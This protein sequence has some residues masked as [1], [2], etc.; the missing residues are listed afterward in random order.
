MKELIKKAKNLYHWL[1]VF[2]GS[3]ATGFPGRKM[4]VIGITGT[5]GKTSAVE[6]L[7][8]ILMASGK[9]TAVLSSLRVK[10]GDKVQKNLTGNTMPGRAYLQRFLRRAEG[11][12]V[13]YALVEVTSEGAVQHRHKFVNWNI[14]AL[15]NLHPEHIESHGSLENYRRAKLSFLE[16]AAKKGAKI[17]LNQNDSGSE[18]FWEKLPTSSIIFFSSSLLPDLPP[19]VFKILKGDFNRDNIALAVAIAEHLH[20]DKETIRQ[21]LLNF[22]GIPG[23][24]EYIIKEPFAVIVDYAH[25]PDSLEAV[26]Q[27]VKPKDGRLICVLGAA[28]G[29][30]DKWKRPVFGK[31]A[32]DYCEEIILTNEDPFDENPE[33]ILQEIAAGAKNKKLKKILDRKNA[34]YEAVKMAESKDVVI[35][36]GKGS[37]PWIRVAHG[38]KIPWSERMAAEEALE[39]K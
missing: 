28:G 6:I 5:K 24:L 19:G 30:R 11:S 39:K 16:Y 14:A 25:T 32:A 36:T 35:I 31:I 10:I 20:L 33:L 2:G 15:T 4:C 22:R 27:T 26:Y 21:G 17:F 1:W 37:E 3:L 38:K 12:K 29:G 7:N 9:R 23:R 13:E 8:A 34:I 18:Y